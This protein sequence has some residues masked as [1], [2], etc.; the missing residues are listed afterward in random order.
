MRKSPHFEFLS[1]KLIQGPGDVWLGL[2]DLMDS[3]EDLLRAL[4]HL[5]HHRFGHKRRLL[6]HPRHQTLS[7]HRSKKHGGRLH[8]NVQ[9]TQHGQKSKSE[10][11]HMLSI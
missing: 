6:F 8:E 1:T 7:R 4:V 11:Y 3:A 5:Q 9:T 10:M 2:A